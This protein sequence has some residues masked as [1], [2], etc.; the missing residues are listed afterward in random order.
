[1]T[2]IPRAMRRCQIDEAWPGAIV[3]AGR[4]EI[5]APKRGMCVYRAKDRVTGG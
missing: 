4:F 2:G 3:V 1:M 5:R